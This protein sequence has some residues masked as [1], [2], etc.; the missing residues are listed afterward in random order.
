MDTRG[1]QTRKE[2]NVLHLHH[3]SLHHLTA[4]HTP[5]I[6]RKA[7]NAGDLIKREEVRYSSEVEGFYSL[8]EPVPAQRFQKEV[9]L[10][11]RHPSFQNAT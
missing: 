9:I 2:K 11:E 4:L 5:M 10:S 7:S 3:G 1:G 6:T 8:K